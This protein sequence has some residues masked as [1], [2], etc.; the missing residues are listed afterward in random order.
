MSTI[1]TIHQLATERF[2]LWRK[3]ADSG[4]T[5]H[6]THRVQA[7]TTELDTLWDTHRREVASG[8][9]V[10]RGEVPTGKRAA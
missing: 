9:Y 1:D 5:A 8:K 2:E 6:E 7:I 4:L 10:R 3:A